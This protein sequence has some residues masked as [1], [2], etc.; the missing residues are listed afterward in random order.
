MRD[1][2]YRIVTTRFRG[3]TKDAVSVDQAKTR[4]YGTVW[5]PKSLI[6]APDLRLFDNSFASEEVTFRLMDWKA[7]EL[8]FA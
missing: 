1:E 4:G 3:M 8:G 5:I 6:C 7:E 2:P